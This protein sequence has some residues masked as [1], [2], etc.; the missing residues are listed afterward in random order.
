ME[1]CKISSIVVNAFGLVPQPPTTDARD[2]QH[3]PPSTHTVPIKN[4][5]L[6]PVELPGGINEAV[7]KYTQ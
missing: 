3:V 6:D 5:A 7:A 2:G 4:E 1:P